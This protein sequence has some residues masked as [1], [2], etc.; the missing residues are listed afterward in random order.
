MTTLRPH[1]GVGFAKVA[2]LAVVRDLTGPDQ[3]TALSSVPSTSSIK[4]EKA[5]NNVAT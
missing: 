5:V 3:R 4:A 1:R 2:S